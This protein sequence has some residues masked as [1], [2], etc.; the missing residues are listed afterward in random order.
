MLG[1]S[2]EQWKEKPLNNCQLTQN[3]LAEGQA[4]ATPDTNSL[5]DMLQVMIT[6]RERRETEI[7][8]EREQQDREITQERERPDQLIAEERRQ[9]ELRNQEREEERRRYAEESK[10]R[11][12]EMRRQM[13]HLQRLVTEQASASWKKSSGS[14]NVKL[15]RLGEGDDIEAYLTTFERIME[16]HEVSRER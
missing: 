16:A 3:M 2:T 11:M 9:L 10:G 14:D 4:R 6:D 12:Q 5:M 7:A 15:T 13:E 1:N 8:R